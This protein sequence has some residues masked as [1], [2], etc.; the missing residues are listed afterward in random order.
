MFWQRALKD[1]ALALMLDFGRI[2]PA[3]IAPQ[4]DS[5]LTCLSLC[6]GSR[7]FMVRPGHTQYELGALRVRDTGTKKK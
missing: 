3:V 1:I 7:K 4:Q 6:H 2:A 5:A